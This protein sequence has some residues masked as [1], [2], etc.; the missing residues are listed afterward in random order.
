MRITAKNAISGR[1]HNAQVSI[2]K[3]LGII[4]MVMGHAGCPEY[5]HDFIY[6]FHMPLFY[7]LSAYFFRD[8]KVV[9]HV[10][11]YV[12]RKFKNLYW[13]YIKWSIIFLL[14]HN[15]FY[16]I[17][18]Y[19]NSLSW[20][21]LFINVKCSIR[22]M[23]QGE[24]MLGAYWFLI[25]LFWES[26]L[27]GLIIWVKHKTKLRYFDLIAV[28]FLFLLGY[29]AP[30]D[31]RINR[32]M[33]ILP[34]FY[35]GYWAGTHEVNFSVSKFHLCM[36]LLV[37]LSLLC[38]LATFMKVH[39][40]L[41]EFYNPIL[42]IIGSLA[43]INLIILFSGLIKSYLIG[44]WLD[45]LGEVTMSVLTFHFLFFKILTLLLVWVGIYP[46]E[47]LLQWPVAS[48]HSYNNL[49]V[50][51][52]LVGVLGPISCRALIKR[53]TLKKILAKALSFNH[54]TRS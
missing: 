19:D 4:L 27:F 32:E 52:T 24:R 12:V 54:N 41:G 3:A 23:W 36:L 13:P 9:N 18:F 47:A 30:I 15:L 1:G 38:Y 42:F 28:V 5:L 37:C 7:F 10:E 25:S 35:M 31:F 14:L 29:F 11:Q 40:G 22:G 33:V 20:Q 50:L 48:G 39:V 6:L 45:L 26:L 8:I 17:G 44:R 51:Y 49:W 53:F 21:E 2:A 16:K 34:I 46:Q 43:G